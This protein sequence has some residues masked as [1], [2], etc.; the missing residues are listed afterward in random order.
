MKEIRPEISLCLIVKPSDEEAQYLNECLASVAPHVNEICITITGENDKVKEVA[1]SYKAKISHFKWID[2]FAAARSFNFKQAT[3]KWI[4]WLDADDILE[5]GQYLKNLVRQSNDDGVSGYAFE[6]QYGFDENGKCNDVHWKTQFVKNDGSA[7]WSGAIHENLQ[8]KRAVS[9]VKASGI[10][11]IHKGKTE[12]TKEANERNQRILLKEIKK[13]PDDPRNYFYIARSYGMEHKWKESIEMCEKYLE[14]SGWDAERYEAHLIIG[15]A[16]KNLQQYDDALHVYSLATLERED[17]PDAYIHK[18]QTY[19]LMEEYGKALYNFKIA[20]GQNRPD[21]IT[22]YN[23]NFYGRD[24]F[25]AMAFCFLQTANVDE[26]K[27]FVRLARKE[28]PNDK[29][30]K[31]LEGLI[32]QLANER[33]VIKSYLEIT[34]YLRNHNKTDLINPLLSSVPANLYDNQV[35]TKIRQDHL[36]HKTWKA[37]SIAIAALGSIEAWDGRNIVNGGIGGSETAIIAISRLLVAEGWSVTVFNHKEAPP[38]GIEVDGVLYKNMWLF[39][40]DDEFDVLWIWRSPELVDWKLNARLKI[41]DLHDVMNPLDFTESRLKEIDKIFVKSNYHRGLFPAIPDEKFVIVGNGIDLDRFKDIKVEHKDPYRCVYSSA[42]NRGLDI[43]LEYIW[44]KIKKA[45][46]EAELHVYYGWKVFHAFNKNNP[47]RMKWMRK[48]QGLMNQEGV[49]D[50]DR[51]G[52]DELASDL[53]ITSFWLYPTYFPEISCITAMEMQASGVV[54][55]TSGYAAL[56]ETQQCGVKLEGDPYDPEW[57]EEYANKVIAAMQNQTATRIE[58]N[59]GIELAKQFDWKL[60][61]KR[62]EEEIR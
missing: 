14:M 12:R 7:D 27:R 40:K 2:D 51:V 16:L 52:Q 22:F 59:K 17:Y 46:P 33:D 35:L 57:Q 26:A 21:G 53:R 3:G 8:Q 44:P 58:A 6:Y 10:L 24:L 20:L 25:S 56:A 31:N 60:V 41:L 30:A 1:E 13:H 43:L 11:R 15:E 48:V 37:K 42:P 45:V 4:L 32:D 62:W 50:H 54:P 49:F 19:M 36:P 61:S 39:N 38:E 18:G 9:W 47:E 5:G 23:P 29:P 28:D 34:K 55:I